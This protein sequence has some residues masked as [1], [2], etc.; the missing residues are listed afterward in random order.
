MGAL[1]VRRTAHHVCLWL[2]LF[3]T[4]CLS[5]ANQPQP[6]WSN[7]FTQ[8]PLQTTTLQ[9]TTA[10]K[11]CRTV[12][13]YLV[14]GSDNKLASQQHKPDVKSPDGPQPLVLTAGPSFVPG[15]APPTVYYYMNPVTQERVASFLPPDAPAAICL[16]TGEHITHTNYGLLGMLLQLP[17][18]STAQYF[19]LYHQGSSLLCCGSL[20][21]LVSVCSIDTSLVSVVESL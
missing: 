14:P 19:R 12:N 15:V 4:Q 21:A 13:K 18:S 8:I 17:S 7:R 20:S 16:Q 10:L 6:Q 3:K 2:S 1:A 9:Q 11:V 5:P